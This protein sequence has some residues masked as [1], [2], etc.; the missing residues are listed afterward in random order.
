MKKSNA[1]TAPNNV[2]QLRL[3]VP[4]R[5]AP[6]ASKVGLL[7]RLWRVFFPKKRANVAHLRIERAR[8]A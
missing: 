7:K 2:Y 3:N 5:T 1:W 4:P 6:M 8:R